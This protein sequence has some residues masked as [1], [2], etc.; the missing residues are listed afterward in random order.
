MFT[1]LLCSKGSESLFSALKSQ[2]NG[3]SAKPNA[4][5]V[6]LLCSPGSAS[7]AEECLC[8]FSELF[9]QSVL[10]YV[11]YLQAAVFKNIQ[12]VFCFCLYSCILVK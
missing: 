6:R 10:K 2:H 5:S 4:R 11:P 9:I 12:V 7:A 3:N 1:V 8:L